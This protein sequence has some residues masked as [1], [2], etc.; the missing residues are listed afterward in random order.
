MDTSQGTG[1]IDAGKTL[2]NRAVP[3]TQTRVAGYFFLNRY[4]FLGNQLLP[5]VLVQFADSFRCAAPEL[6]AL[7]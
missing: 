7:K 1:V 3:I 2:V 6:R 5:P 4:P